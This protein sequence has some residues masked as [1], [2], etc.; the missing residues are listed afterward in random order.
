NLVS[1]RLSI[2]NHCTANSA[3]DEEVAKHLYDHVE[4]IIDSTYYSFEAEDT[5]DFNDNPSGEQYG[6][7]DEEED[8]DDEG[9]E[10]NNDEGEEEND[11]DAG[12]KKDDD[13]GEEEYGEDKEDEYEPQQQHTNNDDEQSDE[14]FMGVD[15]DQQRNLL[16]QFSIQYVKEAVDFYDAINAKT[17]KKQHSWESFQHRFHKVKNRSYIERFRSYLENNGTK[18]QKLDEIDQYTYEKFEKA[19][20]DFLIVHDADLKRWALQKAREINDTTFRASDNWV[21]IFKRRHALC[22]RKITKLI[23]KR[24]VVDANTISNFANDFIS[25]IKKLLPHYQHSNVLNT[26]QSGLEIEMVGNRT[27]SFK[28]EK[29]TFGKVRSVYNTSHSYTVQFIISLSGE[30]TGTCYLCLKEKEGHMSDN[31]KKN[32]FQ[33]FN[34]TVTY[35]LLLLDTWGGQTDEQL[36]SK[37]KHLRLEMIPKKTTA[38][39]QPL[40]TTF[41]R[42]YKHLVR[43]IYDHVRLYDIDCNLSQRDNIIK[44][45]SLCYNQMC[46]KKFIHMH[47]YSWYKGGYLAKSPGSFQNVEDDKNIQGPANGTLKDIHAYAKEN[48]ENL[49]SSHSQQILNNQP[50]TWQESLYKFYFQ[51]NRLYKQ[52]IYYSWRYAELHSYKLFLFIMVLVSLVK[53]CAFNVSLII[54][55]ILGLTL[56]RLRTIIRLLALIISGIYILTSMCYHISPRSGFEGYVLEIVKQEIIEKNIFVKN[57][58]QNNRNITFGLNSNMIPNDTAKWFGFELRSHIDQFVRIYILLTVILTFD[59]IV[60]YRQRHRRLTLSVH[61]NVHLIENRFPILFQQY[62][63]KNLLD[64]TYEYEYDI[65]SYQQADQ[66]VI[67]FLKYLMNFLFYRFGLEICHIITVIVISIHLDVIAVFYAIW[68]G[69]FLISSRRFI[70]RIWFIY[71]FFQIVLFSLQYMSAVGAPPFLCFEYSWTNVNIQGWSQLKRWLYLPDYID[72]PE[73]THLFTDFFQFLFSCQQWHVFGYETNE[74]YRVYTDAGGSNRE[75]IYDYNIYKNNPTWDFV[76]TKRHMLDRIKYAIF[77][78]GR[79]IVL[80]IVYLAGITRI[81]LF[82]LGYLIACFYFLWY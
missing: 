1:E 4:S 41:N 39:V 67:D 51:A 70:K 5:I 57:C 72:S 17:G 53:V 15:E 2:N 75:I 74:K 42:Q 9:E 27:L 16:H 65:D 35:I 47:Q 56:F 45:T 37:M 20:G 29:A 48:T 77:M 66:S 40:D 22:S 24:E 3:R 21:L 58:S 59:A 32:L 11:D 18:Q 30:P 49:N 19:R 23:T 8:D 38:M 10:E 6:K 26:D 73:A 36:Y 78:Y 7:C 46:S 79:W 12:E 31:I 63:L 50:K 54:L 76:T 52:I 33:A 14:I 34:V 55:T 13:E 61:F 43:T 82:G 60:R 68:L 81:S 80:S 28:G 69:L 71:I 64:H 44:L 62:A 25:K